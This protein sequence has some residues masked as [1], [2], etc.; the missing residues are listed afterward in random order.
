MPIV[1]K[2]ID[3]RD[4]RTYYVGYTEKDL[5]SRLLGHM[6][7]SIHKTTIE[8]ISNNLC[9]KI[10][11]IE[12]GDLVT[13]ETEMYWI[14]RLASEG[15]YLEN[16]VGVVNYQNRDGIFEIPEVLLNSLSISSEQKYKSAIEVVLDELPISSS[17]PIVIRIR[18]ILE[19][20]IKN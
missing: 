15:V 18:T 14:K 2:L 17:V 7:V 1:Y 8:L 12:D 20:A 9:P 5:Q 10:E 19:W 11:I 16:R 13:K 4:N 3:P 6:M